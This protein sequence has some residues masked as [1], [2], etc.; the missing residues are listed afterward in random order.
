MQPAGGHRSSDEGGCD[1][2]A[3]LSAALR[4]LVKERPRPVGVAI[5]QRERQAVEGDPNR[6]RHIGLASQHERALGS[7]V[8]LP[9]VAAPEQIGADTVGE[10]D[11]RDPEVSVGAGVLGCLRISRHRVGV[12][13]RRDR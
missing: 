13:A 10:V 5:D 1:L 7:R 9:D 4:T 2:L 3:R 11:C 12:G 6:A 8:G